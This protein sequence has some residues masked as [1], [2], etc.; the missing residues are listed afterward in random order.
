MS[1]IDSIWVLKNFD[2]KEYVEVR[3]VETRPVKGTWG[4]GDY[5]GWRAVDSNGVNYFCN[6]DSF[7]DDSMMPSSTWWRDGGGLFFDVMQMFSLE[8]SEKIELCSYFDS[9]NYCYNHL[10]LYRTADGCFRCKHD[11]PGINEQ[12]EKVVV[13][14][15]VE[16]DKEEKKSS[17]NSYSI[18]M[19]RLE[20]IAL[21][22][23]C[24]DNLR[25]A[26]INNEIEVMSYYAQKRTGCCGFYDDA[27]FEGDRWFLVGFNY[28]H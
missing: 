9:L 24:V 21:E 18:V 5:E 4:G 10:K 23:D 15:L 25:V 28:G 3:V 12:K 11:L 14:R 19:G 8:P 2:A 20:K 27:I 6:W 22:Y 26:C 1:I 16:L 13:N 7:P 17:D